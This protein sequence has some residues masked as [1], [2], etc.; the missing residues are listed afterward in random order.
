MALEKTSGRS[1]APGGMRFLLGL[2]WGV[3]IGEIKAGSSREG[4]PIVSSMLFE[5]R[6]CVSGGGTG[7]A[8]SC[9]WALVKGE[10]EAI[11]RWMLS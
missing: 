1:K 2:P 5:D 10:P 9:L 6:V 8:K 7:R 3:C 11:V 4:V